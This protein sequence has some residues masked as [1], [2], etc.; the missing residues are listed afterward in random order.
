MG[1]DPHA[2]VE[3]RELRRQPSEAR[4]RIADQAEKEAHPDARFA[5]LEERRFAVGSHADP[6]DSRPRAAPTWGAPRIHGELL[7]LGFEVA[8][9]KAEAHHTSRRTTF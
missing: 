4:F 3:H 2:V 1:E 8:Q 9:A 5:E 7:M 6:P